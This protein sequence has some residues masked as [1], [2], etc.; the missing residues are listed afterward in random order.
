MT[1]RNSKLEKTIQSNLKTDYIGKNLYYYNVVDSTNLT[2]KQLAESGE[3]SGTVAV[4]E[5]QL[6]GRGRLGRQWN[7]LATE[8]LYF[9][10]LIRSVISAEKASGITL[11]AGLCVCK[12]LRKFCDVDA[13]IKWPNDIIIGNKK[14]CGILT[15]LSANGINMNYAVI[16]IGI[17]IL[18]KSFEDNIA[19]K[20]S[21][22]YLATGVEYSKQ[23]VLCAVLEEMDLYYN[24]LCNGIDECIAN[25]YR[26]LCAT[27][28]REVTVQ[29]NDTGNIIGIA[30]NIT[31]SGELVI[32]ANGK[33]F[34]V[35]SG[36]VTVQGIY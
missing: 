25:E 18:N 36:E 21:S 28:G 35:N 29:R 3:E 20:A 4:S 9:S 23:D 33:D 32:T 22:V 14:I 19:N 26:G 5:I 10:F 15:E 16:G 12:A 2:V 1:E 24:A 30:K 17:N 27:L 31:D 11:I 6:K 34:I 13:K 7:S 8:S